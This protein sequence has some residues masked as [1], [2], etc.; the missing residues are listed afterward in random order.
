MKIIKKPIN[1]DP[2]FIYNKM[3]LQEQTKHCPFC[4]NTVITFCIK[5]L[6]QEDYPGYWEKYRNCKKIFKSIVDDYNYANCKLLKCTCQ[7]PSCGAV[8]ETDYMYLEEGSQLDAE[9]HKKIMGRVAI[10]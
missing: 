3:I 9:V 1:E 10:K 7:N 5:E 4:K 6:P 2:V 8:W